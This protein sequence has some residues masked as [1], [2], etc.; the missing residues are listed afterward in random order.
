M[1]GG[2]GSAADPAFI[3]S[4]SRNGAQSVGLPSF[5]CRARCA[6]ITAIKL[7]RWGNPPG[8]DVSFSS[9]VPSL[10]QLVWD[11]GQ[12]WGA[13]RAAQASAEASDR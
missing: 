12:L 3:R 2:S 10:N 13:L 7:A 5:R 4:K 6:V 8:L 9:G 1:V 11:F